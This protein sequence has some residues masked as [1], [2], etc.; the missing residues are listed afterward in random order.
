MNDE[1]QMTV[2]AFF[3]FT[4]A[5]PVFMA[6]AIHLARCSRDP[7]LKQSVSNTVIFLATIWYTPVLQMVGKMYDCYEDPER[8][9]STYLV[10]DP[11]LKCYDID[12]A[13]G[14][15]SMSTQRYFIHFVA[16]LITILVGVGFPHFIVS[17][18]RMLQRS[19]KLNMESSLASLYQYYSPSMPY[20]E[21][22]Q[23]LR[24]AA[25]IFTLSMSGVLGVNARGQSFFCLF[26][27]FIFLIV[28]YSTAPLVYYPCSLF[29][30]RNLNNL[31]EL[32][33]AGVTLAGSVLAIIGAHSKNNQ[34]TVN[35]L[36]I[37]FVIIN[38]TFAATFFYGF[39]VDMK[40]TEQVKAELIESEPTINKDGMTTSLTRDYSI[41]L[42][43]ADPV[44]EAEKDFDEVIGF[45][46]RTEGKFKAKIVAEMGLIR[47]QVVVAIKTEL[48]EAQKI[49]RRKEKEKEITSNYEDDLKLIFTEYK[50]M[51]DRINVD[52]SEHT[53]KPIAELD[54]FTAI[55]KQGRFDYF[56]DNLRILDVTLSPS[57]PLNLPIYE[58]DPSGNTFSVTF[59]V[60][61]PTGL[62]FRKTIRG[63]GIV[64]VDTNGASAGEMLVSD[65]GITTPGAINRTDTLREI[66]DMPL[67]MNFLGDISFSRTMSLVEKNRPVTLTFSRYGSSSS[68]LPVAVQQSALLTVQV[69][70]PADREPGQQMTVQGPNGPFVITVPS[71]IPPGTIFLVALPPELN[72]ESRGAVAPPVLLHVLQLVIYLTCIVLMFVYLGT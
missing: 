47:S 39:Y 72:Q 27:N 34:S 45:I 18:T 29:K 17:S 43:L 14:E 65:S 13:S 57:N 3:I 15:T 31:S 24:K 23:M 58:P 21:A 35:V 70:M 44:K 51:L 40:R 30:N 50:N 49:W 22:I 60:P 2:A 71:G 8:P 11:K 54:D 53:K 19:S 68:I 48:R 67:P 1:G 33:G 25:L 64:V 10:A 46:A 55:A 37:I 66:D 69:Q 28:L 36:G 52:F 59:Y 38:V 42:K 20:F 6:S 12:S 16:T 7:T 62:T 56:L 4:L 9:G 26:I 61:E 5:P 41:S 63:G 32:L